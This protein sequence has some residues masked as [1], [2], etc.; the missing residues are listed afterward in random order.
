MLRELT[1]KICAGV[2]CPDMKKDDVTKNI[3]A[4]KILA[5]SK[6]MRG[7]NMQRFLYEEG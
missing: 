5:D 2:R 1:E 4:Y 6:T 7:N 3:T